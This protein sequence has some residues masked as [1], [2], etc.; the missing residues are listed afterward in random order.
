MMTSVPVVMFR[1]QGQCFALEAHTVSRQGQFEAL[2]DN[3]LINFA[4]LITSEP[5]I[6]APVAHWLELY[7][8]SKQRWRLGLSATAEL[9]ELPAEC[10]YPLP[11]ALHMRRHFLALQALAVY[12][13]TLV[14][15][16]NAEVLYGL[17]K[18][19]MQTQHEDIPCC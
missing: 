17:A 6:A 14:A 16:L 15:I 3:K 19:W 11:V 9:L 2:D 7:T 8:Q 5:H 18:R 12:Q 13:D 4:N 10:I 1:H